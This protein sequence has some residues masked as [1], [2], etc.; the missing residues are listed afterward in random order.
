MVFAHPALDD[1]TYGAEWAEFLS[2]KAITPLALAERRAFQIANPGRPVPYGVADKSIFLTTYDQYIAIT[3]SE[4][5]DLGVAPVIEWDAAQGD[6]VAISGATEV[7]PGSGVYPA[8]STLLL[9]AVPGSTG[10][11]SFIVLDDEKFPDFTIS[12]IREKGSR[13]NWIRTQFYTQNGG[14][15]PEH[16]QAA[17]RL[18]QQQD[19][20]LE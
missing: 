18:F 7:E 14:L 2:G 3:G 6:S 5:E 1:P 11:R 8:G 15:Q 13:A 12:G 10:C 20:L 19:R 9:T 16:V 17:V 4:N